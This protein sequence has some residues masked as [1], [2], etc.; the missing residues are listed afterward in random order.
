MDDAELLGIGGSVDDRG[1][2]SVT[3]PFFAATLDEALRVG[4]APNIDR[5]SVV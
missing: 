5:K 2:V 4:S 1:L 3:V